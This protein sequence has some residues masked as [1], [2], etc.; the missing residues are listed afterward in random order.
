MSARIKDEDAQKIKAIID[1]WPLS[2]KITW[3]GVIK[4]IT[5]RMYGKSWTR[6]ALHKQLDIFDAYKIKKEAQRI[7]KSALPSPKL[8]NMVSP[9]LQVALQSIARIE[10]ENSRLK[11]ENAR[12]K[13]M[14][15]LWSS[16][17]HY[18]NLTE[19]MLNHPLPKVDRGASKKIEK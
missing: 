1:G 10:S 19:E 17:A 4:E 7:Y 3:E 5:S 8:I 18:H 11:Q 9:E 12:Y 2:E 16:N 13:E 6:Q 14:F 15:I